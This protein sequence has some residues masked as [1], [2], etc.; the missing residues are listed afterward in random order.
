ME[1]TSFGML[2]PSDI[3]SSSKPLSPTDVKPAFPKR[4]PAPKQESNISTSFK[5]GDSVNNLEDRLGNVKISSTET[6]IPNRPNKGI[7]YALIWLYQNHFKYKIL[8]FD[9][10]LLC[11]LENHFS[12]QQ[13]LLP[14]IQ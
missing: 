4:S 11:V 3:S 14:P 10:L 7:V 8:Q 12:F 9:R 6:N 5:E 1:R 2:K 13:L